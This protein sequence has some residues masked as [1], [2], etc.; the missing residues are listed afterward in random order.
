MYQ[1]KEFKIPKDFRGKN[2]LIV[3][4]WRIVYFFL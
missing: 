4:I 2:Q 1:L 3:Q